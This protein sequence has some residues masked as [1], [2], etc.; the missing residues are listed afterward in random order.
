MTEYREKYT[1][2][3]ANI[4]KGKYFYNSF[5]ILDFVISLNIFNN[6]KQPPLKIVNLKKAIPI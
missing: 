2:K 6:K 1:E 3:I 4:N 5:V